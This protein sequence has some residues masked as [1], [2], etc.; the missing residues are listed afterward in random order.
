MKS[1][2]KYVKS[3][4]HIFGHET[5]L[6]KWFDPNTGAITDYWGMPV[7]LVVKTHEEYSFISDGPNRINENGKGDDI[8][9]TFNPF[10]LTKKP[11]VIVG[12]KII[13]EK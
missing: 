1:L 12:G 3:H 8:V 13:T 4:F 7:S 9:Y 2:S 5:E 6:T 10:D 11:E